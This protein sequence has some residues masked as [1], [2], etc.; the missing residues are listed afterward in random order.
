MDLNHA[1]SLVKEQYNINFALKP[2]QV[3][4]LQ[5]L[6]LK[7]NVMAVLPTGFGKSLLFLMPPLLLDQVSIKLYLQY[8]YN[9]V[10]YLGLN[11]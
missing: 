11:L 6:L 7:K 1:F 5:M 4:I 2:E 8:V 3:E 9:F 10:V